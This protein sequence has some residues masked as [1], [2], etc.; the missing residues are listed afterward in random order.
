MT[1]PNT[2]KSYADIETLVQKVQ[3]RRIQNISIMEHYRGQSK[4][5]YKLLPN[6]TRQFT[7]ISGLQISE[8]TLLQE[9]KNNSKSIQIRLDNELNEKENDW[10]VLIQAQHLGKQ[11]RLLD[12]TLKWQV[13]LWFAVRNPLHDNCNGQFWIFSVPNEIH[14][15]DNRG[16]FYKKD[17]V[18]LDRTYL[19]NTPIYWSDSLKD[20]VA[21]I[22]RERQFGKFSISPFDL[23]SVAL[24]EQSEIANCFEKYI[25]HSDSKKEIR[26]QL[27]SQGV[28][29]DWLFY[30]R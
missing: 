23:V 12:W 24:N 18:N 11:T 16:N 25:I 4:D 7:T 6:I 2:L 28:K 30:N 3:E 20:Q 21:E 8:L 14:L 26:K 15:T 9:L 22:R 19:I 17:L 10:N 5:T 27:E 29:E 13:A 1:A